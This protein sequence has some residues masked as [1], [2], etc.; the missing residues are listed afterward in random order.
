MRTPPLTLYWRSAPIKVPSTNAANKL[1]SESK[2]S[3]IGMNAKRAI[4]KYYELG[5]L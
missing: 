1:K 2:K 4:V 5:R 3:G